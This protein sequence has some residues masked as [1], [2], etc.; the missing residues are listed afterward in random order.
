MWGPLIKAIIKGQD[1]GETI[2]GDPNHHL[3]R[4]GRE[5]QNGVSSHPLEM[6]PLD[7]VKASCSHPATQV[8]R[9]WGKANPSCESDELGLW[10]HRV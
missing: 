4:V 2:K 10:L 6:S 8:Y 9:H 1:G 5:E 7:N 3:L